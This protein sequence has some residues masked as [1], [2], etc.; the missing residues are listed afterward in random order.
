MERRRAA[1]RAIEEG[2]PLAQARLRTGAQLTVLNVSPWGA[3]METS[4]RLLPGRHLD[5]HVITPAGRVL[6]RGRVAR[7]FVCRLRGDAIHYRAALAFE[8]SIDARNP[9]YPLPL[10]IVPAA[11]EPGSP[12]PAPGCITEIQFT[13]SLSTP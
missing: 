1:R 6:V 3:L 2:E 13:D 7:A 8:Q 12:Y 4:E 11:A 9:G 10:G 5:V